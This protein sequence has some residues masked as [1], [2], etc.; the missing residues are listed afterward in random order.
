MNSAISSS[1]PSGLTGHSLAHANYPIGISL[2][3]SLR[4]ANVSVGQSLPNWVVR[5]MSGLRPLA[6]ELRTLMVVR[7]V[8]NS[9]ISSPEGTGDLK[10][11]SKTPLEEDRSSGRG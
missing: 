1:A 2:A 6:T 3:L 7:F 10:G 9:D 8:P 11:E 5:A 4:A